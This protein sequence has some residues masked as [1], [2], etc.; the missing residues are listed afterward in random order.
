MSDWPKAPTAWIEDRQLFVSVPFTW[1]LYNVRASVSQASFLWDHATVGGPAI[2]LA[3]IFEAPFE[4]P[5]GVNVDYGD[6]PGVLN[7]V[8]PIATRTS[9]GCPN[10]CGFCGVSTIEPQ[11][12]ELAQWDTKPIVCDNN[13]LACSSEHRAE[14][15]ARLE[16]LNCL[17]GIVDFN[18]GLD[19]YLLTT[20]DAERL[21]KLKANCR[22]ACDTASSLGIVK[23]AVVLLRSA[24]NALKRI[25]VYALIGWKDS[26]FDAWK[27]CIEIES[28]GVYCC[29]MW[30]H[31]LDAMYWNKVTEKQKALGW[32]HEK[33]KHIMGYFWQHRGQP[34]LGNVDGRRK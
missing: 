23:D 9:V 26:P 34:P 4:W 6:I 22:L 2:R 32:D 20:W 25:F 5:D 1:N 18:Q 14:V 21:S 19:A 29:P 24:K 3:R 8:N 33:R 30:F 13:F 10:S 16:T 17:A 31:E 15:Y 11:F 7:R 28:L 27:R 12:S